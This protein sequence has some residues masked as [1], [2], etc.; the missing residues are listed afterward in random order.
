MELT[1]AQILDAIKRGKAERLKEEIEYVRF[2]EATGKI[3]RGT[4][5]TK[6]R[7]VL[8][9][10]HIQRVFTLEKGIARNI[11]GGEVWIEEKID[12]FNLRVAKVEGRIF[13]FSRGG[14][15]DAFATEKARSM[16][17]ERFFSDHPGYVI[18]GE[19]IGNTPYTDPTDKFDVKLYIFDIDGGNGEY[20][21]CE[22]RY[23]LLKA[24]RM[25]GVPVFGKYR[26]SD[27]KRLRELALSINKAMKEGMVI[28]TPD[29]KSAI[30]Y[31]TP[32]ADIEDIAKCSP[33]MFDM[34]L[35]FY[36][37]RMFRSGLFIK[38]FGLDRGEYSKRLGEAFYSGL[39]KGVRDVEEGRGAEEVFEIFVKDPKTW[40]TVHHHMSKE[41]RLEIISD[42]EENGG[43]RIRFSKI[44][45]KTTKKLHDA[46][47]GKGATD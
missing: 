43:R 34:P 32:N 10:E 1:K 39:M 38:D 47:S 9:Y 27:V 33:V 45:R 18:C 6:D 31:V 15:I 13:A 5:I 14:Y 17:F 30:K 24:Y 42:R 20:L 44:Y 3:A 8:G 12:G 25:E 37:Q 21:P 35:G 29:R 28:K 41:V 36:V 7:V 40:E 2:K 23:A 26:T 19:M 46:I 4:V 11:D 16:G 22:D